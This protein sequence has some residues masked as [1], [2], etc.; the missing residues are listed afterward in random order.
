MNDKW[1][2]VV[3]VSYEI[4]FILLYSIMLSSMLALLY[5]A[6]VYWNVRVCVYV[7]LF[8]DFLILLFCYDTLVFGLMLSSRRIIDWRSRYLSI[9]CIALGKCGEWNITRIMQTSFDFVVLLSF[10]NFVGLCFWYEAVSSVV[11]S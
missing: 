8:Y 4:I 11:F 3:L 7:W 5:L 1:L 10:V 9:F 2:L 6:L